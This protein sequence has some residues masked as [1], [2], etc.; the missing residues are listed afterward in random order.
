QH[1]QSALDTEGAQLRK[2]REQIA[3]K[4]QQTQGMPQDLRRQSDD[5]GNHRDLPIGLVLE[6]HDAQRSGPEGMSWIEPDDARPVESGSDNR[7]SFSLPNDFGQTQDALDSATDTLGR[8]TGGAV[9]TSPVKAVYTVP[10]NATLMGSIAMTALIGR[11][12]ID[13]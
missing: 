7:N 6:Q 2:G 10:S 5:T 4:S 13:G 11:V 3:Y 1:F 12:P 9:G 8:A